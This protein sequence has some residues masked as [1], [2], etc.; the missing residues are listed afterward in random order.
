MK[1]SDLITTAAW[2]VAIAALACFALIKALTT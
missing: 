1:R 2:L